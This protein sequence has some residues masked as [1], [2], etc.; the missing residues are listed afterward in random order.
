MA[1]SQT[2]I[3][4]AE[5]IRLK[6]FPEMDRADYLVGT[7]FPDIRLLGSMPRER[8]HV[9]GV[10]LKDAAEAPTPFFTG[11][12]IHSL[13]D[14]VRHDYMY[15]NGMY[16]KKRPK[17]A[18][19]KPGKFLEDELRREEIADWDVIAA[20]FGE[21][22]PEELTYEATDSEIRR[23]H[24]LQADYIRVRPSKKSRHRLIWSIY[25]SRGALL[26]QKGIDWLHSDPEVHQIL[27]RFNDEFMNLVEAR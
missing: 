22:R 7:L 12:L 27:E 21:P 23:W 8:T 24:N 17:W 20:Y 16:T 13:V 25:P 5:R 11:M 19:E 2:H 15:N 18:A 26:M 14:E 1:A 9:T 10:R 4:F 6:H 3:V